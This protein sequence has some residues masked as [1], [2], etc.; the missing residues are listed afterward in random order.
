[1]DH[2]GEYS[3]LSIGLNVADFVDNG[4]NNDAGVCRCSS[5]EFARNV[6]F[7]EFV[8]YVLWEREHK[9]DVDHHW[10]PQYNICRPCH[11][12]YD[13]IG[14]YETMHADAKDV[15][16]KIAAGSDVQFPQ[17]DFDS[18]LPNS[19]EYLNL[20]QNVTVS[21]LRRILDFYEN[22]YKVFGYKIPDAIRRKLSDEKSGNDAT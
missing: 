6:T 12:K 16:G 15:L 5:P 9:R 10:R 20:F 21:D 13:Y 11:I 3:F 22:D 18:R 17:G 19:N 7:A 14:Y 4:L 1:M 8:G 2:T